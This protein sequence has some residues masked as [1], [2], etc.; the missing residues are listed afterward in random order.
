MRAL[1]FSLWPIRV[2]DIDKSDRF[3]LIVESD[4]VDKKCLKQIEEWQTI[5]N[6]YCKLSS[7]NVIV[8][9]TQSGN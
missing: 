4:I 5:E 6:N 9:D 2:K 3:C 7:G 1:Y 8:S